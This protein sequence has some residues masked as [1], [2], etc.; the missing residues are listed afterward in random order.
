MDEESLKI[1]VNQKR[2]IDNLHEYFDAGFKVICDW[3][4]KD[5]KNINFLSFCVGVMFYVICHQNSRINKLEKKIIKLEKEKLVRETKDPL[6]EVPI[7][8]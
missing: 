7:A 4:R 6:E 5:H 1:I 2:E 8:E 3:G